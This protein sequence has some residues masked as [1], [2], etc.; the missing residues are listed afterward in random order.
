MLAISSRKE[1]LIGSRIAVVAEV[2][3]AAAEHSHKTAL[4]G[5]HAERE[6]SAENFAEGRKIRL[7]ANQPLCS[8]WPEP[9]RGDHFVKDQ[10]CTAVVCDATHLLQELP[11]N[12]IEIAGLY[13]LDQ[14]SRE[15][16]PVL[17]QPCQRLRGS[18]RQHD[19]IVDQFLR[20]AGCYWTRSRR[21]FERPLGTGQYCMEA[22]VIRTFEDR[23][24]VSTGD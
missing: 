14:H 13:R 23:Y 10:H 11:R 12:E 24:A 18:V 17:F 8:L 21:S 1:G 4:P 15:I 9:Q 3:R 19:G 2:P 6:P 20:N 16:F 22:P 7:N 5:D